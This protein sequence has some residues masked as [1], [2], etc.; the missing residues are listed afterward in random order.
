[1]NK[2]LAFACLCFPQLLLAQQFKDIAVEPAEAEVHQPVRIKV[3]FYAGEKVWCGLR[4]DFG[5]NESR[6]YRVDQVPFVVNKTYAAA[7]HYTVRAEG[8]MVVRGL[9]SAIPCVGTARTVRLS[10]AERGP[11]PEQIRQQEAQA[12][13]IRA[14]AAAA[15]AA[16][17]AAAPPPRPPAYAPPAPAPAPSPPPAVESKAPPKPVPAPAPKPAASKPVVKPKDTS[18]KVF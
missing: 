6:E 4:V 10:V 8:A 2:P 7:G 17:R 9:R 11:T 15:A 18:Q 13:Q 16:S 5:D 3:D 12:A 1:M 14:A